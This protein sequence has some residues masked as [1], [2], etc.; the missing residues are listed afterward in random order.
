VSLASVFLNAILPVS[1]VAGVGAL[2]G[3]RTGIDA[4]PLN[5]V[6][7]Y[8]LIPALIFDSLATTSIPP[9]TVARVALGVCAYAVAMVLVAVALAR[10][11]GSAGVSA[12]VLGSTFTNA[13]NYAI[14]VAAFAFGPVGRSTAVLFLVVQNVLMYTVGVYV[15]SRSRAASRAAV[16]EVF[17]LPLVYAVVAAGLA[18]WLD[19]LPTGTAME[20]IRT[21]GD[22][23]IPVMLLILGIQL[24]RTRRSAVAAAAT[25]T[26]LKLLA[27]PVAGVAVVLVLSFD[28]PVV[29]RTFVLACA[30]PTAI[31]PLILAIEYDDADAA[32][33]DDPPDVG[34]SRHGRAPV[35]LPDYVGAA[36][37]ASTLGSVPTLT[38]LLWALQSGVV[39]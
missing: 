10:R 25:P 37:F 13:A 38:V 28:A 39:V 35:S 26:A 16:R 14:P 32:P 1:V 31:T 8:V 11:R 5:T 22:A 6:T 9:R 4:E 17:R 27:A 18:R 29:A 23:A 24:S 33:D 21:T 36:V 34:S 7:I 20:T 19:L 3:A 12:L 2:V 30:A 15:A